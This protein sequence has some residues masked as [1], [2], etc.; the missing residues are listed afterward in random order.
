[1]TFFGKFGKCITLPFQKINFTQVFAFKFK[2]PSI[3]FRYGLLLRE[4]SD[5]DARSYLFSKLIE[6]IYP[7]IAEKWQK[8][9]VLFK[10]TVINDKITIVD[11][12]NGREIMSL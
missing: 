2:L 6:D 11:K 4:V 5:K 10:P 7:K 9:S 8:A 1:M 12:I 3:Y